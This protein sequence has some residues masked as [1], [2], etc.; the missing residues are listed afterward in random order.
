MRIKSKWPEV[1]EK[2]FLVEMWCRE[3]AL[4]KEIMAKLGVSSTTFEEYKK[5]YPALRAALK[6]GKEIVDY[7][8]ENSLYQK[9]MGFYTQEERAFKCKEIY[10]DGEGRRCEREE[11]K[12]V[13]VAVYVPPDTTAIAIWLNN[14]KPQSWR[15]NHHK[16]KLEERKFAHER[17]MDAQKVW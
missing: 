1:E 14:R 2:L 16:E 7:E 4:E 3:G 13:R 9:C 15:R 6:K 12:K 10:Y 8:V 5:K 11:I 17:E